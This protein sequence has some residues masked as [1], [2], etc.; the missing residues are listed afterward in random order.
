VTD[1]LPEGV[2]LQL[3]LYGERK[4]DVVPADAARGAKPSTDWNVPYEE[5]AP[6]RVRRIPPPP[7]ATDEPQ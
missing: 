7:R 5:P 4:D 1:E 3:S 6:K 2:S